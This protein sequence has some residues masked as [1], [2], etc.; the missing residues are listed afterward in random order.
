MTDYGSN[1][2]PDNVRRIKRESARRRGEILKREFIAAYGGACTCCGETEPVFLEIDHPGGNR[3]PEQR[4][5]SSLRMY[6]IAKREGWPP[7][8]RILCSNCNRAHQLLSACPHTTA[9][10]RGLIRQPD[11]L[12]V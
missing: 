7:D 10:V 3:L 4:G 11:P 1:R 5:V 6:A 9:S 12:L 8:Y 2:D